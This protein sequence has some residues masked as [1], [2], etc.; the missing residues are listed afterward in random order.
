ML[1]VLKSK[2]SLFINKIFEIYNKHP[3]IY[4]VLGLGLL[5]YFIFFHGIGTYYLMDVDETR[6]VAMS[7]DMYHSKDFLTLYLNGQYFFEKPPLYFWQECLSFALWGGKINKWTA[8]FPVALLGFI[9]SML[10]YF[11]SRKRISK[12]FGVFTSLIIAT[13]L[14]FIILAKYS[15]LGGLFIYS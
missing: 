6:Y 15:I 13:S 10:V 1:E 9:F 2:F 3:E 11:T 4:T 12:R 7:R 8:R 5:F 14:E